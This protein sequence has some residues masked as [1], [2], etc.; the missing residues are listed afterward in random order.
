MGAM[1]SLGRV[2]VVAALLVGLTG[3]PKPPQEALDA[4]E[5]AVLAAEGRKDCAGEKFAAAEALLA[6]ARA[7]VEAEEFEAAERKARAAERLA[8][9]AQQQADET[10]EDCQRRL[11]AA[12][13]AAEG[14]S[15]SVEETREER[16]PQEELKLTTVYFPYNSAE[17]SE[18]SRQ[19]LET[20]LGWLR[21]NPDVV[22]LLE[23]HTDDRGTSEFNVA[24]GER[25]AR[26]VRDFMIQR[27]VDGERLRTLSYGE[28]KPV[29]FGQSE[30][31]F[32]RNRRVEFIPR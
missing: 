10:W 22:V 18:A 13:R 11:E 19:A 12:R 21:Q 29:A 3:C 20:N 14:G 32:S 26:F 7:H 31:D 25:R 2:S 16:E 4:A 6:E 23:G 17:I 1:K 24:L 15:S 8:R 5:A 27:G 28:E 30:G 9:E